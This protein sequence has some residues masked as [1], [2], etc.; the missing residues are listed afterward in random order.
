M[1]FHEDT[2]I[3]LHLLTSKV[4]TVVEML[5]LTKHASLSPPKVFYLLPKADTHKLP[6]TMLK[7]FLKVFENKQ[8][9]TVLVIASL[10]DQ[11]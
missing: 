5:V 9:I 8:T 1:S 7:P 6:K 3:N 2:L 10:G 11:T 4:K